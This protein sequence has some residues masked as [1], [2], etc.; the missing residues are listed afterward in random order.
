MVMKHNEKS[1][2]RHL[3]KAKKQ[4][5]WA[6][7]WAV[8]KKFGIGKKIHPSAITHIKR[9]WRVRKLNI[10]PKRIKKDYLG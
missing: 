10:K 2:K 3:E 6:P 5:R 4:T 1:K 9:N 7:F 8:L